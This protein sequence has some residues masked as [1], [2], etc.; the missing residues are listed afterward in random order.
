MSHL[1]SD[2]SRAS[3]NGRQLRSTKKT[4]E[5]HSA[6]VT[7]DTKENNSH[8]G[9]LPEQVSTER[10]THSLGSD[11]GSHESACSVLFKHLNNSGVIYIYMLA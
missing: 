3:D 6:D 4:A 8:F 10:I 2:H 7:R 11:A 5:F 1:C 9:T